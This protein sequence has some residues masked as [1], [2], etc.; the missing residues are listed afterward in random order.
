MTLLAYFFAAWKTSDLV[1]SPSQRFMSASSSSAYVAH[2][3]TS[4]N[5]VSSSATASFDVSMSFSLSLSFS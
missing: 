2:V 4:V 5:F 1:V 3:F